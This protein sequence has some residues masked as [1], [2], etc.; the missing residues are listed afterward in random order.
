M[1]SD[2]ISQVSPR[3]GHSTS[4]PTVAA[5]PVWSRTWLPVPATGR[6]YYDMDIVN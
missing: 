6:L 5:S 2:E 1:L 3:S 4:W